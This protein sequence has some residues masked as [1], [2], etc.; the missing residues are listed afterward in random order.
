MWYCRKLWKYKWMKQANVILFPTIYCFF[1]SKFV[2]CWLLK[3]SLCGEIA[4]WPFYCTESWPSEFHQ[5]VCLWVWFVTNAK[6]YSKCLSL[7]CALANINRYV[8]TEYVSTKIYVF[9]ER[10]KPQFLVM[11]L[12]TFQTPSLVNQLLWQLSPSVSSA[13]ASS[14]SPLSSSTCAPAN[15]AQSRQRCSRRPTC[16]WNSLF[17]WLFIDEEKA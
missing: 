6:Y 17:K 15:R 11:K 4:H 10:K 3:L 9:L 16:T 2:T 5:L 8:E 7:D 14:P 1:I 13:A 12:R